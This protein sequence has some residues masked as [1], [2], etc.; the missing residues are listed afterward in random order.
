MLTPAPSKAAFVLFLVTIAAASNMFADD[1]SGSSK[2]T[3]WTQTALAGD[4]ALA[5]RSM[6]QVYPF[7]VIARGEAVAQ[8]S[9]TPRG[10]DVTYEFQGHSHTL[11]DLLARTAAQGFLV[12]KAG[13]IVDER[14][15]NGADEKSRF[16]SWSMAK[17][18][19]STLVGLAV[20][21][22]K[23]RSV[24][25]PITAYLPELKATAYDDV[26]IKNILEMSSGVRFT[27][28]ENNRTSDIW[29]MWSATMDT[30]SETIADYVMSLKQRSEPPGSKWVYR[31]VDTAVLGMLVKRVMGQ[32]LARVLSEKIWQPL[33]MEQDATW[34]TDRSGGL[35]AA[36]CCIN[37]TLRDYGRFGLMLLH[38]GKMGGR[39]IVSEQWIDEATNPQ[40]PQVSYGQLWPTIFPDDTTGYGYQW[41][42]PY[43]GEAHPFSADGLCYQFIYVNPKYDL[44]VVK[45]SAPQ[46]F[47]S[48]EGQNEQFAAFDA[49]GRFLEK[50][51]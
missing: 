4:R 35:E 6:D 38:H 47:F 44:V 3:A 17:S 48:I 2:R 16:T 33:E 24:N 37:P 8:F 15:F 31:S 11:E 45:A 51:N 42:M 49:I 46:K 39:Q 41:W 40:G 20:A 50:R 27:E 9:R 7:S 14:Y 1:A 36:Y 29:K 21:E 30:E 25:D 22:G 43:G 28:D 32:P 19:T 10:L 23:I 13:S 26:W 34:L 5:L 18:F 12:I